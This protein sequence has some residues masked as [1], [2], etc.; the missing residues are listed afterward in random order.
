MRQA[1]LVG[2]HRRKFSGTTV[3]DPKRDPYPD[4]VERQFTADEPNRLWVADATQHG[5]DE[6]WEL[7]PTGRAL[8]VSGST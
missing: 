8:P 3:R 4:R 5:T 7:G 6:G 2:V 1:G